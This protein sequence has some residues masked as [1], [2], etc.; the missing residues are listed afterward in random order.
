M[1]FKTFSV[2]EYLTSADANAYLAQQQVA[3]KTATESVTSST[4][5]QVDDH[6]SMTLN[7]NTNYWLDGLLLTDGAAAGDFRLQW[8][9]PSGT[10][11]W[12]ANGLQSATA[13]TVDIVDRNWKVGATTTIMGTVASGTTTAVHVAGII[14]VS[15]TGGTFRLEWAQGTSSATATRL[16]ANSFIRCVRMMP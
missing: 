15:S 14:R 16:F 2:N 10:I 7:A 9:V 3:R 12:L 6:L 13:A 11:R 5:P 4:S 8:I 1:G